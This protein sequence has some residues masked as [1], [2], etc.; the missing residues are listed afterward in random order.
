M[1]RVSTV[2]QAAVLSALLLAGCKPKPAYDGQA[3]IATEE[4]AAAKGPARP[5]APMPASAPMLAYDYNYEL[6]APAEQVRPLLAR[7][8]QACRA[9][10]PAVCQVLA[11]D[12]Q[13]DGD[14]ASG[15][16]K[17]R[18]VEAW[19]ARF[20]GGLEADARSAGG[21]VERSAV[22]T[23]D[24]TRSIVDTGAALRA[25]TLLRD[26]LEKLLAERPGKLSDLLDLE[27]E[28]AKVQGEIDAGQSELAV[29]NDRVAMSTL[30]VNYSADGRLLGRRATEP[31]SNALED[32]FGHAIAALAMLIALLSY[33]LPLLV[34]A[35]LGWIGVGRLRRRRTPRAPETPG[36][37]TG[38]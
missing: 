10:G 1:R 23:E 22:A 21:R 12:T 7:H 6:R 36:S 19:T 8:E 15:T 4:V 20:R 31:L 18:A 25:K 27:T 37:G 2:I 11:A 16:L 29:M 30:T 3:Q 26:R 38:Y 35:G 32:F 9:A 24:L 33:L 5:A 14:E 34:I 13:S 17:L 28:I